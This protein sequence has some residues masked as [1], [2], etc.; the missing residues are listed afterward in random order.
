M[1]HLLHYEYFNKDRYIWSRHDRKWGKFR[2]FDQFVIKRGQQIGPTINLNE[3][4]LLLL[5]FISEKS[6]MIIGKVKTKRT[7][8]E[9]KSRTELSFLLLQ[10]IIFKKKK[11]KVEKVDKEV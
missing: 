1:S 2:R 6:R 8:D 10:G 3:H 4:S 5:T 9:T 7:D 11:K